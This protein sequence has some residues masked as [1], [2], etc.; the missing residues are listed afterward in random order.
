MKKVN[1]PK[2]LGVGIVVLTGLLASCNP[3]TQPVAAPQ[4]ILTIPDDKNVTV[5][6]DAVQD[7]RVTG[8]NVYKDGAKVNTSPI[9]PSMAR[10]TLPRR[11]QF[12]VSNVTVLS[13]FTVRAI[14]GSG[15]GETS[16]ES[17]SHPVVCSRYL[18]RGTDMGV[19]SQ[20]IALTRASAPLSSATVRVNGTNIP[21]T[22][23]IFQGNLAAAVA[24]GGNL[25]LVANDGNCVVY[26]RD[27]LPEKPVVTAP[28]A[29]ASIS[30]SAALPVT[31]ISATNPDRFVVSATWLE[32]AAGTG[33]RS[34]DIPATDRSFTIPAN[35]LP[36]DKSVKIRVYAYN[37]GTE[38]FIGAFETGSQLA[39][40]H[41]D[42]VGKDITTQPSLPDLKITGVRLALG[43]ICRPYNTFVSA[44]ISVQNIGT[45]ASPSIPNFGSVQLVDARDEDLG[46]GYRGNG[47][48]IPALAA[49]AS[50]DV[51]VNVF[52]PIATPED[53]EGTR[54][55]VA[56]VDF[57]N[58]IV[59]SNEANNRQGDL[60]INIPAG[61]CK[62]RIAYIHGAD[63]SAATAYQTG[64]TAKGLRLTMLPIASLTPNSTKMLMDFD[65]LMIDP[66]T[67]A[68][69]LSYTWEGGAPLAQAI[70]NA[71][72]PVIGL[73]YGGNTYFEQ[74]YTAASPIDWGSSWIITTANAIKGFKVVSTTHPVMVGPFPLT[75]SSGV[76]N[77]SDDAQEYSAAH[78][79]TASASLERIGGDLYDSNEN[80][81][82]LMT[83]TSNNTSI[84][85]FMG[86]PNYTDNGWNALANLVWYRL[87]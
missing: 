48:E 64:L 51:N 23:S 27:T 21:F 58:R 5:L 37:D 8:Y 66:K 47:V 52:Y 45:A 82:N 9:A 6:W 38:S 75:I 1:N 54:N 35:T 63:T 70:S 15:E 80:H 41:G 59:E 68:P 86:T 12:V 31:W 18:V 78:N 13:K 36:S 17:S 57:G 32:G 3:T 53:T 30:S 39:I 84:W 46:A 87:P 20:N 7:E 73:G 43:N 67:Q 22:S 29:G 34:A 40:R 81:F 76:V 79:P 14:T 56:R 62:N 25:E 33:W 83:D 10:A 28:A 44:T 72:R 85:G 4:N 61:H 65:A 26:A 19:Q 2:I 16:P 69:A 74:A 49:G 77:I 42:E 60:S 50:A 24:V 71:N 55:Y 11:L